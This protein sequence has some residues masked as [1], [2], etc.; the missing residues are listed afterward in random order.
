[1]EKVRDTR[2][3]GEDTVCAESGKTAKDNINKLSHLKGRYIE[4]RE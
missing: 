2:P 3:D 1:M 4:K